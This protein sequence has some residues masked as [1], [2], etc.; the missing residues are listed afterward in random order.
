MECSLLLSAT[1]KLP[2]SLQQ[3][4]TSPCVLRARNSRFAGKLSDYGFGLDLFAK[5]GPFQFTAE[6]M[7][8]RIEQPGGAPDSQPRRMDGWYVEVSYHFFPAP[9]RGKHGLFGEESTFALIVRVEGLDLNDR[10]RGT[11]FRDDLDQITIGFDF[12]PVQR[13]VFKI[14]YTF[15]DSDAAGFGGGA[16]DRF[17]MSWAS[18]F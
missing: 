16:A 1:S 3:R 13:T 18:Y 15:V 6:F 9:W 7:S 10:T 14:S 4:S 5:R 17:L 8:L 11:T 12:R 2:V